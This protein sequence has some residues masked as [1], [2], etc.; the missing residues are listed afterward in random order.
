MTLFYAI[1]FAFLYRFL[2]LPMVLLAGLILFSVASAAAAGNTIATSATSDQSFPVTANQ[3]K[4]PECAS[5]DLQSVIIG[6]L[7]NAGS[8]LVIG[9]PGDDILRGGQGD[10]CIVGGGGNDRIN[11]GTGADIILGGEGDDVLRGNNGDDWITGDSG[12]DVIN[13]GNGTDVCEGGPGTDSFL[14]CEVEIP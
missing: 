6:G 11:G 4:P 12:D 2:R 10:D 9:T 13:G 14:R 8:D 3:L 1:R 7:P 5:L